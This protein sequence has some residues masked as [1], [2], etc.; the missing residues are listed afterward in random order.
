MKTLSEILTGQPDIVLP[1]WFCDSLHRSLSVSDNNLLYYRYIKGY[2]QQKTA[3][4]MHQTRGWVQRN[5][6]RLAWQLPRWYRRI[7][8]QPVCLPFEVF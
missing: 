6:A 3:R 2:S 1:P 4:E 7:P 8:K 5:E